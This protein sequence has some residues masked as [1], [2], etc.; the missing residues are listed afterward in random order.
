MEYDMTM[1]PNVLKLLRT[2]AGLTQAQVADAIGMSTTYYGLMERGKNPMEPRTELAI[3][4][5]LDDIDRKRV[6]TESF[7]SLILRCQMRNLR[8][9]ERHLHRGDDFTAMAGT[10]LVALAGDQ[11]IIQ[12]DQIGSSP[13]YLNTL[14]PP[15]A[16]PD[17]YHE[18]LGPI[19]YNLDDGGAP[20]G[21]DIFTWWDQPAVMS[22]GQPIS[23][24]EFITYAADRERDLGNGW[25]KSAAV[26][27]RGTTDINEVLPSLMMRF[28]FEI[29]RG[30]QMK[31]RII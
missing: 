14:T 29:I 15:P 22:R 12:Y 26:K 8:I 7:E 17:E 16:Q 30:A 4:Q 13:G 25:E 19:N 31:D 20:D 23:R 3:V 10:A 1:Q 24:G 21:V 9:A 28:A 27:L 18:C 11:G 5:A 2:L 6:Q